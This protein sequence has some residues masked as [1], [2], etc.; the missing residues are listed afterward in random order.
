MRKILVILFILA[1]KLSVFASHIVGG[2]FELL[3]EEGFTYRLNLVL[4]FDDING[5][6]GARDQRDTVYFYRKSDN[7]N[8]GYTI[9]QVDE[10]SNV[11][12][13]NPACDPDNS[14]LRTSRILYTNVVDLEDFTDPGGYYVSWAR[15]CRNY[16]ISNIFSGDPRFDGISAGQTF[17]LEFPPVTRD[18]S[19]FVNSTP[20]LFPPLSDFACINKEYYTYFGGVDDDGD[21]LVYSLV[22]PYSTFDTRNAFPATAPGPYPEVIWRDGF[23]LD[24]IVNGDPDLAISTDGLLTVTPTTTGL[25]VFAVKVEE[26]RDG[27]KHGEMRRD[28]QM[29][30][31]DDCGTNGKPTI[32]AREKGKNSFYTEGTTLNFNYSD[33]EKCLDIL[34]VDSITNEG[35]DTI[36]NVNLRVIPI[37]FNAELEGVTIDVSQN[38]VIK[39]ELD[40]ARFTV[41]FPDCPYNENGFY[42]LGIIGYDNA[43]PQPRLDTVLVS[44]FIEAPPNE[45]PYFAE[46]R[47]G[48]RISNFNKTVTSQANGTLNFDI[49]AFDLE[50]SVYLSIEPLG[51]SFS[52][53]G[54]SYTEITYDDR[55]A[56]TNFTWNYDCNSND[57]NFSAGRD[58]QTSIGV[59]KAF[60]ILLTLDDADDCLFN[61]A[62]FKIMTLFIEFPNQTK[63]RI[64][65]SS[66]PSSSYQILNYNFNDEVE[67]TIRGNDQDNDQIN[68]FGFGNGFNFSDFGM[69]FENVTGSGNPGISSKFKWKVP[70]P[71]DYPIDSFRLEFYV[72]DLDDC[73][74]SN[75]DTLLLDLIINP[76]VNNPPDIF[77]NSLNGVEILKDSI[78]V[79]VDTE[80]ELLIRA[81]DTEGD[82]I[83]L[84]LNDN[85]P[86]ET[87]KFEN[88]IGIGSVQSIFKWTPSCSDLEGPDLT[89]MLEL[90]FVAADENCNQPLG[91]ARSIKIFVIDKDAGETEIL[92]PNIFTPNKS[93]NINEFFGMYSYDPDT[94]EF[95]NILPNDNC[96]GQFIRVTIFNRWGRTVFES[97]DRDFRWYGE[98]V[99]SGV[100]FYTIEYTNRQ[101]RGSISVVY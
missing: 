60:D 59:K 39:N 70:C 77:I 23:G 64:Y 42:Q 56:S 88:T 63:P 91:A 75:T 38:K 84:V 45:A 13:S 99:S 33:V 94:N 19:V 78:G 89:R 51:F 37:N 97:S 9:L 16:T 52:D 74:L 21:S 58:V 83:R 96:A 61:E 46:S 10:D 40:T 98:D 73:Q 32:F 69:E 27:I 101:Y 79:I 53:V 17:Y 14:I 95:K 2:E 66:K 24:N 67:L 25:F 22:T 12:Y 8:L 71:Y 65:E 15:C 93:D 72:E 81:L 54:M 100:Y 36:S 57:L 18:G 47:N 44:L 5:S 41:C 28:F 86:Q 87:F 43:C 7:F 35:V 48:T 62:Q 31:I 85:Q 34:V 80:I 20:R 55:S 82:T 1:C 50:D 11:E 4:Y 68:I 76:P 29:L 49:N 30:V 3:H 26:F 92:P 6:P 90:T